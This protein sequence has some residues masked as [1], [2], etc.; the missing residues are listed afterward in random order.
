MR[1]QVTKIMR[2]RMHNT[3][4]ENTTCIFFCVQIHI[5]LW[6]GAEGE[7]SP[8]QIYAGRRGS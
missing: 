8:R 2:I 1:I 4:T 6:K 7:R 3:D 5:R